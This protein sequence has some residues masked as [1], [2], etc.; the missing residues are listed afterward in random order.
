MNLR[1]LGPILVTLTAIIGN[2]AGVGDFIINLCDHY[3]I[4]FCTQ[5]KVKNIVVKCPS[6]FIGKD[7]V[8]PEEQQDSS[9]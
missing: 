8:C 5:L 6:P 9:Q 2:L 4:N 7:D 1:F 3:E